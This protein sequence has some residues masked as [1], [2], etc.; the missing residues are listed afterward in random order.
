[1]GP[2][3]DAENGKASSPLVALL[4]GGVAGGVE[5]A[6]TYPFEFAKTRVQLYGHEGVRNPFAVVARVA[7][8][9]GL[10]ALYKGCSTMIFGSIGKDAVRFLMFD[11]IRALFEDPSS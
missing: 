3:T 4:A 9:E 8:Q 6:C 10:G 2:A 11:R 7:R 5:A 1:M